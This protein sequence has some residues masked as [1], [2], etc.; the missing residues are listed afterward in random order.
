MPQAG[1]R[2]GTAGGERELNLDLSASWLIGDRTG[3][4]QTARNCGMRAVLLRT[5]IGG[6]DQRYAAA[7]DY[8][9]DDLLAAARF[10]V[11]QNSAAN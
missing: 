10:I 1:R 7:P 5:G 2:H 4:I 11:Q 6:R 8:V 3:D 9:F